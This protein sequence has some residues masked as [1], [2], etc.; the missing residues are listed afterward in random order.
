MESQNCVFCEKSTV[1][2]N[3]AKLYQKGSDTIK[4]TSE[5]RSIEVKE[6]DKVHKECRRTY[7][8]EYS[9]LINKKGSL[10]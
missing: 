10:I 9:K 8:K 4:Q 3:S 6:G 2:C 7:T 1:E 5:K